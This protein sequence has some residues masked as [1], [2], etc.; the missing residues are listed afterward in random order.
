MSNADPGLSDLAPP[1]SHL[2]TNQP[3]DY[4]RTFPIARS[5][6]AAI[7]GIAILALLLVIVIICAER[8]QPGTFP[9][10]LLLL[11]FTSVLWISLPL[12]ASEQELYANFG[13]YAF[14]F[15][16]ILFFIAAPTIASFWI[17]LGLLTMIIIMEHRRR[18][19]NTPFYTTTAQI[20][21]VLLATASSLRR[22]TEWFLPD[23]QLALSQQFSFLFDVLRLR[24]L[25]GLL[26]GA[27][28]IYATGIN[29][30]Q[31]LR[32]LEWRERRPPTTNNPI[33]LALHDIR[34]YISNGVRF[35]ANCFVII[36]HEACLY[37]INTIL[38]PDLLKTI[39]YSAITAVIACVIIIETYLAM[40]YLSTILQATDSL[41]APTRQ[42]LSAYAVVTFLLFAVIAEL[43]VLISLSLPLNQTRVMRR[44]A[45]QRF[46]LTTV[47]V[48]V[49]IWFATTTAWIINSLIQ[50]FPGQYITP[51]YY[52]AIVVPFA[53][54]SAFQAF[55]AGLIWDR[56]TSST[57]TQ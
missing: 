18:I 37:L 2:S 46:T 49:C 35:F 50:L 48:G 45:Y 6:L 12:A 10:V 32:K 24:E 56:S 25:L 14:L 36:L 23:L 39:L 27:I 29:S 21:T 7:A 26:F 15:F 43:T 47:G 9:I 4:Q 57:I 55:R 33:R 54:W 38:N 30:L 42:L 1:L 3:Q 53:L 22:A 28:I 11:V 5:I 8:D 51:G 16:A 31:R 34:Y 13:Y 19:A 41:L 17:T 44:P 20:L 52:S 40:P